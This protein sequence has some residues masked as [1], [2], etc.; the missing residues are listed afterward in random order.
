M[1]T[2]LLLIFATLAFA[3]QAG[4]PLSLAEAETRF[5]EA[6]DNSGDLTAAAAVKVPPKDRASLTWLVAAATQEVPQNPFRKGGSAWREAESLRR[7]PAIPADQWAAVIDAQSL[8]HSGSSLFFWRWGQAR[9]RDGRMGKDLRQRWEDALLKSRLP[10]TLM[11]YV[12]RHALCFALA[13]SDESRFAQIKDRWSELV[14]DL[15]VNFQRAFA[16]LGSPS[17]MFDLWRLPE[18]ALDDLPLS[19]VGGSRIWMAQDS[20]KD[21]P[22]LPAGT[23]WIVPTQNGLQ[24]QGQITLLQ[25]SLGEAKDLSARLTAAHRT[26]FLAPV[27]KPFETYA[28]V[29]FPIQI[30]L[31]AGGL[32]RQ[33]RMGDAALVK[34]H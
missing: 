21:L 13:E 15:F 25:P 19:Q 5:F 27:R 8:Q 28:L 10:G 6:Y 12:L 11:A 32:I 9:V 34:G 24:P 18:I 14:P 2:L 17:P 30:E 3:L 31:D 26:A 29:Y 16:L 7:L 4:T 23:V 1:R 33:I 22:E 20:G